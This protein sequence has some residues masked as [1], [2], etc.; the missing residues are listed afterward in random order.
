[1]SLHPNVEDIHRLTEPQEAMLVHRLQRQAADNGVLLV[2]ATL[3]GELDPERFREAWRRTLGAHPAARSSVHWQELKHPV[4]VVA[5]EVP[6]EIDGEDCSGLSPAA[7]QERLAEHERRV[8]EAGLD[9]ATAPVMRWSLIRTSE[10]EHR[11]HWVCHHLLLDGWSSSLLLNEV[12][13]RY[14]ALQ[15]DRPFT[16]PPVVRF[17]DWVGWLRRQDDVLPQDFW[18]HQRFRLATPV[19]AEA[20]HEEPDAG[21]AAAIER[22]AAFPWSALETTARSW[23][24]TPANILLGCWGL[25]LAETTGTPEAV[26]GFTASGRSAD[27]DGIE[28]LVG[29]LANTLPI[30]LEVDRERPVE[31]WFQEVARTQQHAQRFE[32]CSLGALLRAGGYVTRRPMFDTLFTI[33]NYPDGRAQQEAD[34]GTLTLAGFESDVTSGYPVTLAVLPGPSLRFRLHYRSD[35]LAPAKAAAILARFDRIVAAVV[36]DSPRLIGDLARPAPGEPPDRPTARAVAKRPA[37]PAGPAEPASRVAEQLKRIWLDMLDV[38]HFGLDDTFFALGG[39]SLLVPRLIERVRQDFGIELP[40]GAV[41]EAPTVRAMAKLIEANDTGRGWRCVVPIRESGS[42]PPLYLMHLLGGQIGI[43]YDLAN[44]LPSDQPVFGVQPPPEALTTVTGMAARY[45]AEIRARQPHG[46]YVLGGFCFGGM[47][48]FEM[49]RQLTAAGEEVAPLMLLDCLPPGPIFATATTIL[50]TPRE[51]LRKAVADPRTFIDL[52]IR[53]AVRTARRRKRTLGTDAAAPVELNEVRDMSDLPDAYHE[54][55]MRHFR[56]G[57]D[58]APE[59]WDGEAR[60]LRTHVERFA[61]DLGWRELIR[62]PIEIA[63]IPG[64]HMEAFE[65]PHVS[66][67]GRVLAE[68]LAAATPRAHRPR[69]G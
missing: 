57:R 67:T 50:P 63:R 45:I 62:G 12:M 14:A 38:R 51:L 7:L 3:E 20:W 37:R 10:R 5:A 55:S 48:A 68:F 66:E 33:A 58:Y 13:D 59:P 69:E 53:R 17:R 16:E 64:T 6:V 25:T 52:A 27:F 39:N 46:P 19:A 4:Q 47:V 35:V 29:M 23:R 31:S 54:S 24:V 28:R 11:L 42:R 9:I 15:A 43:Y 1:M 60:L 41:F 30:A 40:L 65:E 32:R 36:A 44:R 2:R 26:F 34:P 8:R 61:D 49:A 22:T 18:Q 21:K 56:A